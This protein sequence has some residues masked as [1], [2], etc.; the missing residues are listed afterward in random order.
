MAR[1]RA[2][3]TGR[4][5]SASR[6]TSTRSHRLA[7]ARLRKPVA[8]SRRS[9][10]TSRS[11]S[12]CRPTGERGRRSRRYCRISSR[13]STSNVALPSVASIAALGPR[14]G[15]RT[16]GSKRAR[17][18]VGVQESGTHS[19]GAR[20]LGRNR[21]LARNRRRR[22]STPQRVLMHACLT[23]CLH[24]CMHSFMSACTHAGA[25]RS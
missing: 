18:L 13:T 23:V 9:L 10:G 24:V 25:R 6:T 12:R 21:A 7:A 17:G 20:G 2:T 15:A 3:L 14:N 4:C 22:R 5:S 19:R 11:T 1:A 16:R 8:G